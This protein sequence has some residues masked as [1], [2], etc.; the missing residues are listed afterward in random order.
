[1]TQ[2]LIVDDDPFFRDMLEEMVKRDGHQVQTVSNGKEAL[3]A[4]EQQA[5]DLLITDIL[6]PEQDGIELIMQ[7]A[8]REIQVPIIA[9]SGGRRTI[10]HK[11]NLESARLMG[12]RVTLP[13]PIRRDDL[14]AAI[15]KA[16]ST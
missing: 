7:L 2:V 13:K 10:S 12:V 15:D 1:M 5:P 11:F 16:L 3:A 4:I 6:M 8:E 9:I 14:R